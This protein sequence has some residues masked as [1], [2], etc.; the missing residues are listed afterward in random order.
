MKEKDKL[1]TSK[2]VCQILKI[3]RVTLH[4]LLK[5]G[6]IPGFKVGHEWRFRYGEVD[7]YLE[8]KIVLE[9][10]Y[11][12]TT[13]LKKYR[14]APD[15]YKITEDKTGGWLGL[16]E[17]YRA[18]CPATESFPKIRFTYATAKGGV[19]LLRLMPN[20]FNALSPI[21]VRHWLKFELK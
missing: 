20:S 3:H 9:P 21:E 7:K 14:A 16:T 17:E 15:K 1:L 2:E 4:R 12:Y 18:I 10:R 5:S 13:V 11:F 19:K 6:R 8:G